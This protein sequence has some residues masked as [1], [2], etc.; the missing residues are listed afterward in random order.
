MPNLYIDGRAYAVAPGQSLLQAVL[1]LGFRLPYFCW[2]PA[3]GSVGACRQ[4]AVMQFPNQP[5]EA[6]GRGRLVMACMTAVA[7]D[8]RFAIARPEVLAFHRAVIEGLMLHHPHD[9]PVCD[10]GG[11]CHLQDMTVMSGHNYRRYRF[12][13]RTFRNQYLGPLLHHEMNRCIQCYRCVRFYC[14]YAGGR[15]LEAQG[16]A[17]R[18]F[19]GRE[20]DGVLENE[21]AGN[22]AEVCPTGVFTDATL[23]RRYARKWDLR[24][25]PSLCVHCG[26]GCNTSPGARAGSVR[27]VVNRYHG[28]VNGYFLCDRGRFGHEALAS[29]LRVR[30]ARWR[31]QPATPAAALEQLAHLLRGRLIGIGSPRA[32]LESNFALRQLVGPDRFFGGLRPGQLDL[33]LRMAELLRQGPAPT[34]SLRQAE[35]CDAALVLGEDL[36]QTAPRLA[37]SLRQSVRQQ[38]LRQIC[39]PLQIPPW[40]DQPVREAIQDAHGPLY[41]ATPAP[42]RLDDIATTCFRA[43][44]NDIARLGFEIAHQLDAAAPGAAEW[45]AAARAIATALAAAERPLVIAGSGLDRRAILDAAANIVAALARQGKQPVL[46]F[47]VPECNTL[48]LAL[49]RP[50]PLAEGIEL[51][52]LG[53]AEA[54]IVVENDLARRLPAEE[55][56]SL[57]AL[58]TRQQRHLAVLD[59][60]A[61][62]TTAAA[63][64]L[65][66]AASVA[67]GDGTLVSS[68]GRAQRFFQVL[69]PL[70]EIRESWRWLEQAQGRDPSLDDLVARLGAEFPELAAVARAAPPATF[71]RAQQKIPRETQRYSGRTAELAHVTVSEPKPPQ[72]RDSALSFTMEGFPPQPPASLTSFFWSPGW[73]SP[74]AA[75]LYQAEINGPLRGGDAGVRLL[76]PAAIPAPV[77]AVQIPAAFA[78]RSG[79]WQLV[80]LFHLFGSEELSQLGRAIAQLAPAPYVAL[81][82]SDAAQ[83]GWPAGAQLTLEL[84]TRPYLLPLR[85]L[86][87]L[88]AGVAGVPAGV[89]AFDGAALPAWVNLRSATEGNTPC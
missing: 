60:I 22:L 47:V 2:H 42:T 83:A 70:P 80:R 55:S 7:E 66:P 20:R 28:E 14:D 56:E 41:M 72:D 5:D 21:F 18:V 45:T 69:A 62:A 24:W 40:L 61:H 79:P 35:R 84:G 32:S 12:S 67:E 53:A 76:E 58:F 71:R 59:H 77:Y 27:A 8:A 44:P 15:D 57:L 9:C 23:K 34:P 73:N 65:L 39:D 88:A 29:P 1:G 82:P 78:P 43:A 74:Q 85:L 87:G 30:Q 37:L 11:H 4:C 63:E 81:N 54:A 52:R 46:S 36:T 25:A 6:A 10:E 48:G 51:L 50:R 13:K 31:G 16:I 17:D 3:L 38:P 75:L 33:A 64:L 68:E 26:L 19:F 89:P 49:L 86:P